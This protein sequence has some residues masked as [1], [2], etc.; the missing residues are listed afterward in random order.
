ML[1]QSQKV[2]IFQVGKRNLTNQKM[3]DKC[4]RIISEMISCKLIFGLLSIYHS[5]EYPFILNKGHHLSRR[6]KKNLIVKGCK[7]YKNTIQ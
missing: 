6:S 7:V 3:I 1:V 4:I 2:E 5:R